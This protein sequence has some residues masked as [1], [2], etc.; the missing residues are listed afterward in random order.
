M[1]DEFTMT[2][3]E[4]L[5]RAGMDISVEQIEASLERLDGAMP[6]ECSPSQGKIDEKIETGDDK[7][8]PSKEGLSWKGRG[9][10]LVIS[11]PVDLE[12]T[13]RAHRKY[14]GG[15]ILVIKPDDSLVVHG[16]RGVN[17]VSY[18][19]RADNIWQR[20][21]C[22]K[23]TVTAVAGIDRLV[24]TF[25]KVYALQSLFEKAQPEDIRPPVDKPANEEAALTD[26]EKALESRLRKLRIELAR[27]DGISFLPA[28]FDNRT[29]HRLVRQRPKTL[30][31][32]KH[33]RG[34]GA[35]RIERYA[36]SVL[37]AI[38]SSPGDQA[39]A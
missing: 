38:N 33:V 35:K 13:G 25:H 12:Y 36:S 16:M 3:K 27:R 17:P 10:Y 31:E 32:L 23:L 8:K 18:V 37:E 28:I 19:A 1:A 11:G 29:M 34:F 24:V 30:E 21:E 20:D 22:G 4:I 26:E 6:G 14:Q 5:D 39:R 9:D 2:I 7:G 15:A